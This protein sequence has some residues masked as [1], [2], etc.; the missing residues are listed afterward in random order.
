M[1]CDNRYTLPTGAVQHR[2]GRSVCLADSETVALSAG[3]PVRRA[4][5]T[6][7]M[8]L[9]ALVTSLLGAAMVSSPA[10]ASDPVDTF[11][12]QWNGKYADFDGAYG[13]QCVDLFN[14]Y[15][16]DVVKAP[17]IAV[18]TAAQL[19]GAAPASHYEKLPA[20]AAPRKG[21]VAVWGT[22]W[23]YTSA[24][25]VAIV[26]A[27]Q[28]GN[29]QVL[30][31]NPGATKIASMTKSYLSGYLRPRNL[32]GNSGANPV[33]NVDEVSSPA[34]GKVRVRGWAFDP[35]D[36]GASLQVH[37]YVGG[38]AG[39]PGADGYPVTA[40]VPRPDVNNIHRIGG[41]HGF[42]SVLS[43]GKV[44]PTQ[45][46]LYAINIG[47]GGNTLLGCRTVTLGDPTP[48]GALDEVTATPGA[49]K[50]RGWTFDPDAPSRSLL[51]HI[52]IG[53]QPGEPGGG[54]VEFS[55]NSSR[56]DVNSAYGISGSHG[57][58]RT[59]KTKARGAQRVCAYAIN[60]ENGGTNPQI[61][62]KTVTVT[63]PEPGFGFGSL[64]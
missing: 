19:F 21:D 30:T 17:R 46:C 6:V 52:Y 59:I 29:I 24:G 51:V 32:G 4:G 20:N 43:T 40:S 1:N 18:G 2:E 26:L 49:V 34:N 41:D 64:S 54:A 23:P 13:A 12:G 25:H 28:G 50:V 48:R 3:R 42:D 14:F 10:H 36:S 16:R 58:E 56:P 37:V 15:N 39:Q 22:S 27:D 11:V 33:G 31:Q 7:L 47:G 53:P 62:C 8:C 55:A 5:I 9:F 44:G 63:E 57:F 45:V 35:D 60:I 38:P 61:G